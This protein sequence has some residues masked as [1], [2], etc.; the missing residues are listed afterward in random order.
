MVVLHPRNENNQ[1]DAVEK[2]LL[3]KVLRT[4]SPAALSTPDAAYHARPIKAVD[5]CLRCHGEP[6]GATDPLNHDIERKVGKPGKLW[7][8]QLQ[9]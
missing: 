1:P 6:K 7:E 2:E 9:G 3:D 8:R 4:G 5:W